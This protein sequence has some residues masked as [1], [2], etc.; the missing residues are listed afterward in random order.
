MSYIKEFEAEL[1][2]QLQ[3]GMDQATLTKWLSDKILESYKNGVVAG[4]RAAAILGQAKP[5]KA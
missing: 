2:K 5:R 3:S 1:A 4:K